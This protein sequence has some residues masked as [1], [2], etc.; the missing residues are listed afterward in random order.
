MCIGM[1]EKDKLYVT[2]FYIWIVLRVHEKN[3]QEG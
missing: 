3:K 1:K 2:W